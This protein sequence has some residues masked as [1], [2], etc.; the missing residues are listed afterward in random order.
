[1]LDKIRHEWHHRNPVAY[2]NYRK[3]L[4]EKITQLAEEKLKDDDGSSSLDSQVNQLLETASMA[5]MLSVDTTEIVSTA[6][7]TRDPEVEMIDENQSE[8]W[9]EV[10]KLPEDEQ[11]IVH[12]FYVENI[13]QV[14]IAKRMNY[15]RSK[16]CRLHM[17]I[18]LKLK[19]RLKRRMVD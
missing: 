17:Q 10:K 13:K 12:L 15:S 16:V 19:Q 11:R 18:L 9:E 6:E 3:R 1:M 4:R 5:Y 8:L 7:G 2:E 14:D